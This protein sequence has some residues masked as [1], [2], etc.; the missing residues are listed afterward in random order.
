MSQTLCPLCVLCTVSLRKIVYFSVLE[1]ITLVFTD[2]LGP[3]RATI[4]EVNEWPP[5]EDIIKG[6]Q[7]LPVNGI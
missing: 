5:K 7:S 6:Q 2:N 1:I 4:K 3:Q